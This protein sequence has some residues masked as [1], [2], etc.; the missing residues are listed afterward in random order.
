MSRNR[1][2]V[3]SAQLTQEINCFPFSRCVYFAW[4]G[5]AGADMTLATLSAWLPI[6]HPDASAESLTRLLSEHTASFRDAGGSDE[7]SLAPSASKMFCLGP[8]ARRRRG[9][10]GRKLLLPSASAGGGVSKVYSRN[11]VLRGCTA[12]RDQ[13]LHALEEVRCSIPHRRCS[14]STRWL[15]WF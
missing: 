11:T 8:V 14:C 4:T 13:Q 6:P 2:H 10:L 3:S 9:N 15:L 12:P 5:F 1:Q 7:P